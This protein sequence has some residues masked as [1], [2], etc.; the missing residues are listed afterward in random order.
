MCGIFRIACIGFIRYGGGE[1]RWIAFD[2]RSYHNIP[3]YRYSSI[4]LSFERGYSSA[5]QFGKVAR[6]IL[7]Q[8]RERE[9]W[10]LRK[11]GKGEEA[12]GG[13]PRNHAIDGRVIKSCTGTRPCKSIRYVGNGY[14]L[15]S[16][17]GA[18]LSRGERLFPLCWRHVLRP[19]ARM[20]AHR[21]EERVPLI[22]RRYARWLRRRLRNPG[23]E[24][25]RDPWN[26]ARLLVR[27]PKEGGREKKKTRWK[28]SAIGIVSSRFASID[29]PIFSVLLE[30]LVLCLDSLR[31]SFVRN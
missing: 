3:R 29:E 11:R 14:R 28:I 12:R 5:K 18:D 27:I 22:F 20:R 6:I 4:D 2:K 1:V 8:R 9:W 15:L 26:V 23:N 24:E 17:V 16:Q 31:I 10:N 21:S 25:V 7:F 19:V 30:H 13:R